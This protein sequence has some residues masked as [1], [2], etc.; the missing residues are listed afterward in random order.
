MGSKRQDKS[1]KAAS[2]AKITN[3]KSKSF[4]FFFRPMF[5]LLFLIPF[6]FVFL[7]YTQKIQPEAIRAFEEKNELIL[8]IFRAELEKELKLLQDKLDSI[9]HLTQVRTAL[10]AS[11]SPK[12]IDLKSKQNDIIKTVILFPKGNNKPNLEHKPPISYIMINNAFNATRS[13]DSIIEVEKQSIYLTAQV[14]S[15]DG[16]VLG[17]VTAVIPKVIVF[18]A[19]RSLINNTLAVQLLQTIEQSEND[20]FE[21]QGWS[22]DADLAYNEKFYQVFRL[23]AHW[24]GAPKSK[25]SAE[26]LLLG[27]AAAAG[28]LSAFFVFLFT[29]MYQRALNHDLENTRDAIIDLFRGKQPRTERFQ[30]HNIA[31]TYE[32]IY[33]NLKNT[34]A[35][36]GS[37]MPLNGA[38]TNL[39]SV[40]PTEKA[41]AGSA[42]EKSTF[43]R[44]NHTMDVIE[45]QQPI[46]TAPSLT[47]A[48]ETTDLSAS[49]FRAYDIRGIYPSQLNETTVEAIG[50]SIGSAA[51][52]AGTREVTVARDGRTSGPTLIKALRKGLKKSGVMVIDIGMVPTPVLYYAAKKLTQG[53]GVMLTGSH[54]P[55]DYNGLKIMIAGDTLYGE[56]IQALYTRIA[57]N[58]LAKGTGQI[59]EKSITEDYQ[60]ELISD[61]VLSRAL[62]VVIDCGNG[63]TGVMVPQIFED[64]GVDAIGLFTEV[65]GTFPNHAPDPSQPDNMVTLIEQVKATGADLGL[66]F[67]GDGDRVGVITP[68]G[69]MV[70][71][72]KLMMLFSEHVLAANPGQDIIYDVKCSSDLADVIQNSGGRPIMWKTGHSLI[73]AKLRETNAPLAGEMSGHIFFNDRWNGYDDALYAAAR[74]LEILSSTTDDLDALL[75]RYPERVATPELH[76]AVTD[77]NKFDIIKRLVAKGN[78]GNGVTNEIDGIRV[79]FEK[80][81]G[82]IRASN[83]TPVLVARFEAQST[84]VMSMIQ[85][86]FRE[87]LQSVAPEIKIPF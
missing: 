2:Q 53:T 69:Q 5:V 3:R 33:D 15:D 55:P 9:A 37:A 81:W 82:L 83:T 59:I 39:D 22:K 51:I 48:T 54:N 20:V 13:G 56:T 38:N 84:E 7:I 63:V 80:G 4:W 17:A 43:S 76:V 60:A 31:E 16:K 27:L 47:K 23:K 21:S 6:I 71:A 28:L 25:L 24:L 86:I 1:K 8:N 35:I 41:E 12:L 52:A 50:R 73:K 66:A 75:A 61:I 58:D 46:E 72:D 18:G 34:A 40:F 67:D 74:L 32:N 10:Q 11:S 85:S 49:I 87:N 57:T 70:Y 45:E 68:S 26:Y 30:L 44:E 42:S 36:T 79:D 64:L 19:S 65:D 78:F 29:F 62:K 77:A 14:N